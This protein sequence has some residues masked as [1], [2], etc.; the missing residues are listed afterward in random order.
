M[1]QMADYFEFQ[2]PIENKEMNM[3]MRKEVIE[4]VKTI[5][6]SICKG[7]L[8]IELRHKLTKI[9]GELNFVLSRLPEYETENTH[10]ETQKIKE[11]ISS[12]NRATSENR[13]IAE[14]IERIKTIADSLKN[15]FAYVEPD[16]PWPRK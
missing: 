9:K 12:V 4:L 15:V 11:L 1:F 5:E 13:E 16:E 14:L 6:A 7:E 8:P 10:D 2:T 3:A